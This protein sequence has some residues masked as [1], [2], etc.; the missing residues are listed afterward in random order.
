MN[1]DGD[2]LVGLGMIWCVIVL[3]IMYA[4]GWL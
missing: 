1:K 4:L 2:L 3:V